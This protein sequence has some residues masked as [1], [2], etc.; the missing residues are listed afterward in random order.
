MVQVIIFF[1]AFGIMV[2]NG[3]GVIAAFLG[4]IAISFVIGLIVVG[5]IARK[6]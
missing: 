4:A 5:I 3:V 1:I 6:G 2:A